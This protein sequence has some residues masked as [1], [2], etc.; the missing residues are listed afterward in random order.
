ML[1]L[2]SAFCKSLNKEVI[3]SSCVL[4]DYV[5]SMYISYNMC[6]NYCFKNYMM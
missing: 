5:L 6:K 4:V 1:H 3:Y 2:I